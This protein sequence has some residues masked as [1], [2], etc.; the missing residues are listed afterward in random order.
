M[1]TWYWTMEIGTGDASQE[2]KKEVADLTASSHTAM[3]KM[4]AIAMFVQHQ[5]RY[6]GIELGIGGWQPHPAKDI[7]GHRYGD[8]KDK[9]TLMRSMLQEI[10]IASYQVV[11]NTTRGAVTPITPAYR[12]FNHQ[13]I[14]IQLPDNLNSPLLMATLLHPRLGRLLFFD[15]TDEVTPF[16]QLRG[17]LQANYGLLV[18]SQR[19]ELTQRPK[20]DAGTNSI[21][22]SANLNLEP[23]G[24]LH[25]HVENAR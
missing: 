7:F 21:P 6:V 11:I 15:P 23:F 9:A 19:G 13:I 8:C 17:E 25:G 18:T 14:A 5:I 16:G 10:G 24:N 3:E 20:Q 4:Q 1:G 2:I 12:G 22:P